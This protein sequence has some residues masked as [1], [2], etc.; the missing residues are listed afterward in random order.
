MPSTRLVV[1]RHTEPLDWLSGVR[2]PVTVYNK[3]PD[4]PPGLDALPLPN[5]GREAHTYLH[6]I[7][8]NYH[9]LDDY[10]VFAQGRPFDHCGTFVDQVNRFAEAPTPGFRDFAD[11]V[12]D[13]ES[14]CA[15]CMYQAWVPMAGTYAAVWGHAP[16]DTPVTF[17]AGAQFAV[18][19]DR[20][21]SR[22]RDFYARA[23][24]VSTHDTPE[25]PTYAA[26]A[27]ERLWR[28]MFE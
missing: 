17:G 18:S 23:L 20:I 22:P 12:L 8:H 19:R 16:P 6:H 15:V 28:V 21:L 1:A 2:C 26:H 4:A 7:V 11:Q 14:T 25:R 5:V 27:F 3:G 10:T 13:W 24:E 9:A